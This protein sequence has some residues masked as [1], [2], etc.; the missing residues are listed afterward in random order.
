MLISFLSVMIAKA[1]VL[2]SNHS[3]NFNQF[4]VYCIRSV[5]KR[6]LGVDCTVTVSVP[7]PPCKFMAAP[8]RFTTVPA[9]LLFLMKPAPFPIHPPCPSSYLLLLLYL[10]PPISFRKTPANRTGKPNSPSFHINKPVPSLY[11]PLPSELK[12]FLSCF[13]FVL[14]LSHHFSPL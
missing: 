13:L 11:R 7:P 4:R 12:V 1:Q 9:T 6:Q 10:H 14:I 5:S 3:T 2:P 8:L